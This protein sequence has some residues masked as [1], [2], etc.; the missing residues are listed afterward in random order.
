[1]KTKLPQIEEGDFRKHINA[2]FRAKRHVDYLKLVLENYEWYERE[3]S[4][5][6]STANKS[7][8]VYEFLVVY[9]DKKGLRRNIEMLGSHTFER[10]AK[11]IV[12]SMGWR[13]DHM[14]GFTLPGISKPR[15]GKFEFESATELEFFAPGWED[16]PFPTYKSS[17]IKICHIDYAKHPRLDFIF[18][19]GECHEFEITFKGVRDYCGP[20]EKVK[21]PYVSHYNGIPPVQYPDYG[22]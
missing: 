19:F 17:Q 15:S 18:D 22:G 2:A 3:F 14:H 6:F 16:D 9:L 21:F 10:F 7:A 5:V 20:D 1:M 4:K 11:T 12:K 13:Y 8:A